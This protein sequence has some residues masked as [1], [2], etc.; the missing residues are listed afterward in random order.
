V[1]DRS[2]VQITCPQVFD[3]NG[4]ALPAG[5]YDPRL[6]PIDRSPC[7]TCASLQCPGH[8]GHIQ[9]QVPVYQPILFPQL[10]H[11]LRAK[12]W[13]C[14]KFK[15]E[16]RPLQIW[17]TKH[18]LW[19]SGQLTQAKELDESLSRI[20]HSAKEQVPINASQTIR[21]QAAA[22]ALD[23]YLQALS[24]TRAAAHPTLLQTSAYK[25]YY[26]D[27]IRQGLS[28]SKK[29]AKCQSCGASSPKIRHDAFA[30]IFQAPLTSQQSKL[31]AAEGVT[32]Q[33][34]LEQQ[35]Q[36][37][38]NSDD[39][40]RQDMEDMDDSDDEEEEDDDEDDMK[41]DDEVDDEEEE[42]DL[43]TA[44]TSKKKRDKYLHPGEVEA[45]LKRT[46]E[47]EPFLCNALFGCSGDLESTTDY[48]FYLMRVVPVPP[49]RFRPPMHLGDMAVEHGQTQYLSSI[50]QLHES[51][52]EFFQKGNA[53]RAYS[54]WIELQ[55]VV[56]CFMDSS[57]DPSG[58]TSQVAAGIKQ[59]LERKE[60]LFRKNMM[61][62]RVDY[63]CRSVISPDPYVGTNEIG[64]PHYFASI[65]T[66]PTPVTDWNA[67]E[68][69]QMVERGPHNYPGARWVEMD[70]RR[71]DLSKMDAQRREAIAAQLLTHAKQ[72]MPAL[73]GR[74]L[75]D[76]DYVLMNRQVRHSVGV[77]ALDPRKR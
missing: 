11:I 29:S 32:L 57:R 62:K 58:N 59:L 28:L 47:Q 36:D 42:D 7:V 8:W 34:A 23:A 51:V 48:Q 66:Y 69:R 68:M 46:W 20:Q 73:V 45:Q 12:C 53:P 17:S 19:R 72:G 63:A 38:Y 41:E 24:A 37:G 3:P 25:E 5:L 56:N 40:N 35:Q 44:A 54:S 49:S 15:A 55:T 21:N 39:T 22:H 14:H 9:L 70:G 2:V 30:K 31:N 16:R 33:S 1:I 76:G 18:A 27:L 60:G 65:L 26:R 67:R 71:M 77:V 52:G 10:L 61:G 50:L 75:K 4:T 13:A 74:Q 6:G 43:A 64:L